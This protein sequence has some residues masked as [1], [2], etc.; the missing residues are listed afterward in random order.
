MHFAQSVI[1]CVYSLLTGTIQLMRYVLLSILIGIGLLFLSSFT[2]VVNT[3]KPIGGIAYAAEGDA[4]TLGPL[5][6]PQ[7]TANS[8][9]RCGAATDPDDPSKENPAQ[10]TPSIDLGC[11]GKGNGI[12]D[13]IFAIIR[14]LSIGVGLVVVGSI[15]WAGI[16]YSSSRGDPQAAANAV[17]RINS[18]V[19]ALV[20]YIFAFAILNWA[21]PG[22]VLK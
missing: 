20:I 9:K 10:I 14:L 3:L 21:I 6:L 16:Q 5:Q 19:I 7:P 4:P 22:A 1:A 12:L 8:G 13:L 15:T 2:P 11:R 18:A 17:K